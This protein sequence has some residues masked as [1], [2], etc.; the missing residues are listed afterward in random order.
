MINRHCEPK[1]KQSSVAAS[2][3]YGNSKYSR[4]RLFDDVAA[5]GLDCF[6]FGL[7]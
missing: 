7:Q 5:D 6:A 2:H 1:A 4:A 3:S